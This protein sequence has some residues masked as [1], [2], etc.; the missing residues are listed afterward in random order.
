[1]HHP[2]GHCPGR[3]RPAGTYDEKGDSEL[4]SLIR[5]EPCMY[6]YQQHLIFGP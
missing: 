5:A 2:P 3:P 6:A 4:I 1:M